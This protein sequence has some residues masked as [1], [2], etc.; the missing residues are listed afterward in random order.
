RIFSDR[1]IDLMSAYSGGVPRVINIIADTAL[2]YAYSA[3][4]SVVEDATVRQVIR[5]KRDYGVFAAPAAPPP[6]PISAVAPPLASVAPPLASRPRQPQTAGPT[7]FIK[8]E[9]DGSGG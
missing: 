5:D 6:S 8:G 7:A 2:V 4:E 1:A 9:S 3:Q